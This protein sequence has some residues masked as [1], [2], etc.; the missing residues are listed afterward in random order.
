MCEPFV[1]V[2][3]RDNTSVSAC[4]A[5]IQS[6]ELISVEVLKRDK[7]KDESNEPPFNTSTLVQSF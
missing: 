3:V 7:G 1:L 2:T 4:V 5:Q 6:V